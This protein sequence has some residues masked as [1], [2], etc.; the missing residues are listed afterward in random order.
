[1]KINNIDFNLLSDS[2]I[3]NICN[4]YKLLSENNTN[5]YNRY[6]YIKLMKE[7]TRKKLK[8][9]GTRRKSVSGNLQ[10]NQIIQGNLLLH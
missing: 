8:N 9:Y 1:M 5:Q 6:E 7:F 4:K 10:S 3:I 2:E